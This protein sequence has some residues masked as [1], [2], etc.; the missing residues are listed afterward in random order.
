MRRS[1]PLLLSGL[2]LL[3]LAACATTPEPA[4][5]VERGI[6]PVQAAANESLLNKRLQWGGVIVGSRNLADATELQILAYPLE[7]NGRPDVTAAPNGRFIARRAGY[8]ETAD[9]AAGRQVTATGT[10]AAIRRGEVGKAAYDFPLLQ[11]DELILWPRESAGETKPRV[12]FG[13]G[14]GSGGRSWGGVGI[15]IG[16]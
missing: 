16:F 8:L 11:A 12:N 6:T 4:R 1:I 7:G 2:A 5:N 15:G 9:Y 14:V 10:L 3:M 13:F